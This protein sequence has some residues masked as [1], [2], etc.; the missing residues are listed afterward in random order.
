[1][2][3]SPSPPFPVTP[4][5]KT[6]DAKSAL[7]LN[8]VAQGSTMTTSL[9]SLMTTSLGVA[10]STGEVPSQVEHAGPPAR[11]ERVSSNVC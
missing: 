3:N 2:P 11:A 1:M 9:M 7:M 8:S 10:M 4:T 5:K 6:T